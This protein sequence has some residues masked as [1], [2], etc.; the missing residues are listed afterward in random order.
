LGFP[1]KQ[2]LDS[3][4][5]GFFPTRAIQFLRTH[6]QPGRMFNLYAWGG[7]LEWTLT[8]VPPFIDGRGDIF[9][10]NGSLKDY[11]EIVA[12]KNTQELLER[13]QIAYVLYQPDTPLAYFLS[14]DPQW[15]R[16]YGDEQ[17]VILR[18][19]SRP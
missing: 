18:S 2:M 14:K 19:R 3:E 9:E 16:I 1:S 13:Y 17:A 11:E 4:I 15:E 6:P 10:Y 12:V 8:Q 7:Y 5:A